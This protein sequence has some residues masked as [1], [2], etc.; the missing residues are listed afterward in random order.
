MKYKKSTLSR[1]RHLMLFQKLLHD[2]CRCPIHLVKALNVDHSHAGREEFNANSIETTTFP[3][4]LRK[5][6]YLVDWLAAFLPS[7]SPF[8][9]A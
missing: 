6:A 3:I 4:L 1:N 8:P 7:P 5:K 9:S 2:C